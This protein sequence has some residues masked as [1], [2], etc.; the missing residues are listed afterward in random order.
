MSK[1][2][3][4]YF[5]DFGETH[6]PRPKGPFMSL[7]STKSTVY[8]DQLASDII[9]EHGGTHFCFGVDWSKPVAV[10]QL[11]DPG[12][13][14]AIK[15]AGGA[16]G[17][18]GPGTFQAGGVDPFFECYNAKTKEKQQFELTWVED[19]RCFEF[20]LPTLEAFVRDRKSRKS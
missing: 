8:F 9:R 15:L 1:R 11:C 20:Q 19:D 4:D 14:G 10:V 3:I 18:K 2:K 6:N 5:T 17:S 16:K 12:A 13:P 7:A